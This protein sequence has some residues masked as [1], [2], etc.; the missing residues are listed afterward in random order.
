LIARY[1]AID[2]AE[3]VHERRCVV[4]LDLDG[5][6]IYKAA[7][8]TWLDAL[9]KSRSCKRGRH[10]P[11]VHMIKLT[12]EREIA[13]YVWVHPDDDR[14]SRWLIQSKVEVEIVVEQ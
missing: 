11:P 4:V 12:Q 2:L 10:G 1:I 13:P 5:T 7:V 9:L 8:K 6:E 14:W 3:L